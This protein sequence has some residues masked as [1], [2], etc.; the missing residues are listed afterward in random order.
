[1]QA[2]LLSPATRFS[3]DS[4]SD[5]FSSPS[6]PPPPSLDF[7]NTDPETSSSFQTA[8]QGF[9]TPSRPPPSQST[10]RYPPTQDE[11]TPKTPAWLTAELDEE[12]IPPA[13]AN[14]H[15]SPDTPTFVHAAEDTQATVV[16]PPFPPLPLAS[17]SLS[18][19]YNSLPRNAPRVPSSLRHAFT[20]SVASSIATDLTGT[21][22][23]GNASVVE[24]SVVEGTSVLDFGGSDGAE[25]SV[26]LLGSSLP[27]STGLVD[28]TFAA[29]ADEN[30][31]EDEGTSAGTCLVN[32]IV[33]RS[34]EAGGTQLR[35]AVQALRGPGAG[36]FA[37]AEEE[38]TEE[39][40]REAVALV[41]GKA[42]A[43]VGLFAPISPEQAA[44]P[45]PPSTLSSGPALASFTF[46]P[47][48]P[49]SPSS[50]SS[51]G[52]A[53]ANQTSRW[54]DLMHFSPS[55]PPKPSLP[56]S[57]T[58]PPPTPRAATPLFQEEERGEEATP[59]ARPASGKGKTAGLGFRTPG[60]TPAAG[61]AAAT[62]PGN[63]L[64]ASYG[65]GGG[66]PPYPTVPTGAG[67]RDRFLHRSTTTTTKPAKP[68]SGPVDDVPAQLQR[69]PQQHP[70]FPSY[71]GE[72]DE[73]GETG[74]G[75]DSEDVPFVPP[76][77]RARD[78]GSEMDTE[79]DSE[80]EE[81]GFSDEME[82]EAGEYT[83]SE[84]Y[85]PHA[86]G[87]A[88][89]GF[90]SE[91]EVEREEE[92][93]YEGPAE[94]YEQDAQGE[95]AGEAIGES[96]VTHSEAR[97]FVERSVE[98][99]RDGY[100]EEAE[101]AE[102]VEES[103]VTHSEAPSY[104]EEGQEEQEGDEVDLP[105]RSLSALP[106]PSSTSYAPPPAEQPSPP[107][108][109]LAGLSFLSHISEVP[110]REDGEQSYISRQHSGRFD[111]LNSQHEH[112]S[113]R[114][115][116]APPLPSPGTLPLPKSPARIPIPSPLL[117]QS[118]RR[119]P[120]SPALLSPN[121]AADIASSIP[122][123]PPSP[124]K[125]FQPTY[126]TLTRTHLLSLVDEID[127][128]SSNPSARS[129]NF[130]N[131][132]PSPPR[133]AEVAEESHL[134]EGHDEAETSEEGFLGEE[135]A[136]RSS[137]R[138][139]LSP[140][141]EFE[142]RFKGQGGTPLRSRQGMEGTPL[143][144]LSGRGRT[145]P[146]SRRPTPARPRLARGSM[147]YAPSPSSVSQSQVPIRSFRSDG[148]PPLPPP[149]PAADG[150]LGSTPGSLASRASSPALSFASE[151]SVRTD[152]R[153]KD[154]ERQ[155]ERKEEAERVMERI[156]GLVE[157]RERRRNGDRKKPVSST[158]TTP[159]PSRSPLKRAS[160]GS[161]PSGFSPSITAPS[162]PF[163]QATSSPPPLPHL[164]AAASASLRATLGSP[165]PP[166]SPNPAS[167]PPSRQ[168]TLNLST[169]PALGTV[170][171]LPSG[172]AADKAGS[173]GRRHFARAP[174]LSAKKP[175]GGGKK[176]R[177]KVMGL[178][179]QTK[180]VRGLFGTEEED[181]EGEEV[182]MADGERE[183]DGPTEEA[184]NQE[185]AERGDTPTF[186]TFPSLPSTVISTPSA[187][188]A[189]RTSRATVTTTAT[190]T[191][192]GRR[193][194]HTRQTSLTTLHPTSVQ[195]Q[196]LLAS[197]GAS[198]RE[199]GLVFDQDR[200][201]WIRTPR[202]LASGGIGEGAIEAVT[203]EEE[204]E[205]ARDE[206]SP[207][208]ERQDVEDAE[209][210]E[211]EE[212]DPF[213]D[214]SELKSNHSLQP[215]SSSPP[216]AA[217]SL[218]ANT[219]A[220]HQPLDLDT[221][222][223][224]GDGSGSLR[225]L[226][227][228]DLSGLGISKGT[229]PSSRPLT[230]ATESP[231]STCYFSPLPAET[232]STGAGAEGAE[233]QVESDDSATWGRSDGEKKKEQAVKRSAETG[234]AMEHSQVEEIQGEMSM[235]SLYQ[236]AHTPP[237]SEEE[238]TTHSLDIRTLN[239]RPGQPISTTH[240]RQHRPISSTPNAGLR[241]I[242]LPPSP[243]T[244]APP[245]RPADSSAPSIPRPLPQPPRSA[246]KQPIR[247]H[248][249][250]VTATCATPLRT[251]VAG[252]PKAPRSVSFSDGK[253]S[254]KIKGLVPRR[255]G[256]EEEGYKPSPL[257]F[258]RA[259]EH[260]P[261][262]MEGRSLVEGPGELELDERYG[263]GED[264]EEAD[265]TVTQESVSGKEV[266]SARTR[267]IGDALDELA[268]GPEESPFTSHFDRP[269][270]ADAPSFSFRR[271]SI[272]RTPSGNFVGGAG[273]ATFLTECS[274]GVSHDRLLQ[275]ITDVEPFEPDWEGLGSIDL[276]GKKA[277]S[278]VRM[279]EFLPKLDEV[280]LNNNELTYLTGIPPSLR[281]LLVSSNR[282]TSLTSFAHLLRLERLDLSNNGLDSVQQ[283]ACLTHLRELKADGNRISSLDGLE[284]LD[285]LVKVSLKGNLLGALDFG[286]MKWARLETLHLAR[287]KISPVANLDRLSS[288]ST[289]NLDHNLLTSL[290][291]ASDMPRL[292]VLRLCNNPLPTL[293]ISFAP[294]LRT[295]YVDSAKLGMLQGTEQLRKLE[296]LSLRDQSGGAL[297]LS[298]P[299]IRDVKRLYLSGNPL[300]TSF[301]SEK[302]FNLVYLELA[303]CQLTSLP[304]NLAAVIPNVR[305]LNVDYNF[306][307]DLAPLAGLTRLT[308]LSA[309]GARL[310][311]ARPVA[312]VLKSLVE[313]ETV[314]FRMNPFTLAFYPPLVPSSDGLLPSHSEHRILHPDDLPSSASPSSLV[315][316][317]TSSKAWQ[318][319]DTKFR[320]AL[321]D[322]WY[323]KRAAYRA[324]V[325][326]SAPALVRLDGI[327]CGRERP[328]LAKRLE[329]L[330]KKQVGTGKA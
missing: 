60:A 59:I 155:K 148:L 290:D 255:K 100:E 243:T 252:G 309:V 322:E 203:E 326:Q 181:G 11:Q 102:R 115:T 267:R 14:E 214:F 73:D 247:S 160:P 225:G 116:L 38:E 89:D 241:T 205:G 34:G 240:T 126:D 216:S 209:E 254:G 283:L 282:L 24:C 5:S 92:G 177:S 324:V 50:P 130:L 251:F 66:R 1:M 238:K 297:T 165:A 201:R 23:G 234:A 250:P 167:L 210:E 229:P 139:K 316:P 154:R 265:R 52:P 215:P 176:E 94:R 313:L 137:K 37:Q 269:S 172:F 135:G 78:E 8:T 301:P 303:M 161:S 13:Q 173:I 245:S 224:A 151:L 182:E 305:V 230:L 77:L 18:T 192:T 228:G 49:S 149:L 2:L 97:S 298:M 164:A 293:D 300:P 180:G 212:E 218:A 150:T 200:G 319:L 315:D 113:S 156:R 276:S 291:P 17:A 310:S 249:D 112:L 15:T 198:A 123:A 10:L 39:P 67:K 31:E 271:R 235:L 104:A 72:E 96:S 83:R 288:L 58:P 327:D 30:D 183:D 304:T 110:E 35:A 211:E 99:S 280:D 7:L 264:E 268:H 260:A 274:F 208:E 87:D 330:A 51:P 61:L 261:A 44:T 98:Q 45:L 325:L 143:S 294:K 142:E 204:G 171:R 120:R 6:T 185:E 323:H 222:P 138:I 48:S 95:G 318:A 85:R 93:Q 53:T 232:R 147:P 21:T 152:G 227:V 91:S 248:S 46:S 121:V 32:S 9:D 194:G 308:K 162:P 175:L 193:A 272:G 76:P 266:Q 128:L 199:K 202:R 70:V 111:S 263:S 157:K 19:P 184:R 213:R 65:G 237:A 311:K 129:Q 117:P 124:Y 122:P 256:E 43:L 206:I 257:R 246:L 285:A 88:E 273:N 86:G 134:H 28:Q 217:S 284:E 239:S 79:S 42:R 191:V 140:K 12:W 253:T 169:S 197:A 71:E 27:P 33:E 125:L 26:F 258:G 307:D 127:S 40:A 158:E 302:F 275:Y 101:E 118:T 289:L 82:G 106:S 226:P 36:I 178:L 141:S 306:L 187:T 242:P 133:L 55:P 314:D 54:K 196:R 329:K 81:E 279:K 281:T 25:A 286:R 244:P 236:A 219:P 262:S 64:V 259:T 132:A 321:P 159:R 207:S 220:Q 195:A 80:E 68:A 105:S 231:A 296:N 57:S 163:K 188:A 41:K 270:P 114:S 189:F 174:L 103:F 108:L 22:D 69:Q 109:A 136:I 146:S 131:G 320:R 16:P 233:L 299:H 119:P 328:K 292:R 29:D 295:L 221:L 3:P 90:T 190:G 62:T 75:E 107:S 145:P 186:P 4:S 20:A 153:D 47:P 312:N 179:G 317:S 63:P 166:T 144:R 277:E 74:T 56:P 170:P 168:S 287:N 223:R 84:V 278:V